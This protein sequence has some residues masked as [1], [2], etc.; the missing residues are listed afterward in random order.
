FG[1]L[2]GAL[3]VGNH[4]SGISD[5]FD[6]AGNNVL[7]AELA[8]PAERLLAINGLWALAVGNGTN[9]GNPNSVLFTAGINGGRD[10][11]F[12]RLA[13]LAPGTPVG[14]FDFVATGVPW[15]ASLAVFSAALVVLGLGGLRT[16]PRR[17]GS[18]DELP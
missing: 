17:P 3:L 11:V 1:S 13:P 14:G 7:L 18:G 5:V 10:G 2:A 9:G 16:Q 8:D 6:P 4:G 15:P 12:G